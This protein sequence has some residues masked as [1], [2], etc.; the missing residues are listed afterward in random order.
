[1]LCVCML[2]VCMLCVHIVCACCACTCLCRFEEAN[3]RQPYSALVFSLPF[4]EVEFLTE[5]AGRLAPSKSQQ[6][7][8]LHPPSVL[9]L[10]TH[11][12]PFPASYMSARDLNSCL[13]CK[14]S[15]PLSD[16][17]APGP[18]PLI[19]TSSCPCFCILE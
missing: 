7:S 17:P 15:F 4:P 13:L 9:G 19:D 14:H 18:P 5:P 2:C 1:M 12:Q 16:L 6:S 3:G 10:Q 8:C 11:T